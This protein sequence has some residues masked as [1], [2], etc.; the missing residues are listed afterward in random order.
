MESAIA[1]RLRRLP[2]YG[3]TDPIRGYRHSPEVMIRWATPAD[4]AALAILAEVDEAEVPAAPLLLAV[5]N[6]EL[7]VA[8]SVSSGETICDP[9]RPSAEVAVLVRERQRQLTVPQRSPRRLR[10]FT[11][12]AT[13]R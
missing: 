10:R 11:R 8:V 4:A 2:T 13:R 12:P 1:G 9:F 3:P 7:W 5:V 6:G